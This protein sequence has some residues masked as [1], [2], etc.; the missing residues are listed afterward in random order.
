MIREWT[1]NRLKKLVADGIEESS[2][3]EYKRA[4][5]LSKNDDK[6][7]ADIVK[8]VSAM[9][10]AAGGTIVYGIAEFNEK[11]KRHLPEKLDPVDRTETSREWLDSI[12]QSIQPRIDGVVIHPIADDADTNKGFYVVEV[13]ASHTAHQARDHVYYKRR[14]F[15]LLPMEDYEVRDV[16]N[17]KSHPQI[18]ASIFINRSTAMHG[19]EGTLLIKLENIGSVSARHTMVDIELPIKIITYLSFKDDMILNHTEQDEYYYQLRITPPLAQPPLF[20]GSSVTL[21]KKFTKPQVIKSPQGEALYTTDD[22]KLTIYADEMP[23]IKC[24]LPALSV[25]NDWIEVIPE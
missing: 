15:Q 18:K 4:A 20:P 19:Q 13:P 25:I 1:I 5:A 16:M 12:I 24:K 8:Q 11:D 10:N 21:R 6:K 9:A 22:I 3:L 14:N 2:Q 23:P 7:K 17:R